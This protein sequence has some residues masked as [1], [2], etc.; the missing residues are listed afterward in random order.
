MASFDPS[1]IDWSDPIEANRQLKIQLAQ[2]E[3]QQGI[4]PTPTQNYAAQEPAYDENNERYQDIDPNDNDQQYVSRADYN[5]KYQDEGEEED[6]YEP[7]AELSAEARRAS[8]QYNSGHRDYY[9]EPRLKPRSKSSASSRSSKQTTATNEGQIKRNRRRDNMTFTGDKC[10]DID[11]GNIA[12]LQR[13]SGI[14]N[15]GGGGVPKP[16]G[17]N[18]S[19]KKGSNSINMRRKQTKIAEENRKF[20]RRLQSVRG[21]G[22]LSK[23]SLRK[24]AQRTAKWAEQG[25]EVR[26]AMTKRQKA[27]KDREQR[28]TRETGWQ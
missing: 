11:R 8:E 12:L 21:T 2:L 24:H 5:P 18:V 25:R 4:E 1:S 15:K 7:T 28:E 14:H 3:A 9:E 13:L 19:K 10:R 17:R 27:R 23:K 6:Y 22:S 20:A 16:V 26:P